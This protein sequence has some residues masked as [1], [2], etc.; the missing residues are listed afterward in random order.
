MTAIIAAEDELV[1]LQ[2]VLKPVAGRPDGDDRPARLDVALDPGERLAV[3][4][5]P[6]GE[7]QG[8]VAIVEGFQSGQVAH[9]RALSKVQCAG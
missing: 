4:R 5:Q 1:E 8:D 7:E 6:A 9:A 2:P 3:D